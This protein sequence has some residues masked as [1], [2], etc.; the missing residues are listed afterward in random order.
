MCPI[1]IIAFKVLQFIDSVK[2]GIIKYDVYTVQHRLSPHA[3]ARY[4]LVCSSV[5]G[6][7]VYTII[8]PVAIDKRI[9]ESTVKQVEAFF[10]MVYFKS[11]PGQWKSLQC[12]VLFQFPIHCSPP[13]K[14]PVHPLCLVLVPLP[15]VSVHCSHDAHSSHI[16]FTI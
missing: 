9:E 15:Q 12:S 10:M 11:I 16:P 13:W 2:K 4:V 1:F 7:T 14:G 8:T 3:F 6:C 5:A